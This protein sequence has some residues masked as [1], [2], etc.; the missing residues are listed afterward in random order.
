VTVCVTGFG[1]VELLGPELQEVKQSAAL[2]NAQTIIIF[3]NV[4]LN[5]SRLRCVM[6]NRPKNPGKQNASERGL[7]PCLPWGSS[8][9]ATPAA[10]TVTTTVRLFDPL[11]LMADVLRPHVMPGAD[12][13]H[14]SDRVPNAVPA[15]ASVTFNVKVV[16][17]PGWTVTEPGVTDRN[18]P[19]PTEIE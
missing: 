4:L 3:A 14:V 19:K 10:V 1:D 8:R 6:T 12:G 15:G 9:L 5:R 7:F 17:C 2:R 16:L 18:A 11:K 13:T